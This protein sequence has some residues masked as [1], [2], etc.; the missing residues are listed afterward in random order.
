M[1]KDYVIPKEFH[2]YYQNLKASEAVKDRLPE[3]DKDEEEE[4]EEDE[5]EEKEDE[6]SN[7]YQ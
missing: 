6:D 2:N 5:E 1:C 3:P 7:N 4:E